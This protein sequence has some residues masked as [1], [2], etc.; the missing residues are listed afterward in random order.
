MVEC[1]NWLW[2]QLY[3]VALYDLRES[4][5]SR[6]ESILE[7]MKSFDSSN[8]APKKATVWAWGSSRQKSERKTHQSQSDAAS[9]IE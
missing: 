8:L 5:L 1:N 2:Q 7:R 6:A 3:T 4:G 9:R